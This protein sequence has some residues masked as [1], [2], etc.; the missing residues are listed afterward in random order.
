MAKPP[1][2]RHLRIFGDESSQTGH[3][4]LVYGTM[5]CDEK[6]LEVVLATLKASLGNSPAEVKWNW[7]TKRNIQKYQRFV[8]AII[9]CMRDRKLW[10][11]CVVIECVVIEVDH[12]LYKDRPDLGLFAP[13]CSPPSAAFDCFLLRSVGRGGSSPTAKRVSCDSGRTPAGLRF[14]RVENGAAAQ[15]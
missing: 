6:N 7:V 5:S 2:P 13:C 4:F 3:D 11:R 8:N 9:Q 1:E 10:F 15:D 12:S 14:A